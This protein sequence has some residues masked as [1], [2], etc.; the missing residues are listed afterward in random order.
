MKIELTILGKIDKDGLVLN[1]YTVTNGH[2][3]PEQRYWLV[4]GDGEGMSMSEQNLFDAL[5]DYFTANF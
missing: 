5:H 3:D 4:N 1:S 2:Q